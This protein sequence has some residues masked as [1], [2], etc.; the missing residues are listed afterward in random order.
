MR[1]TNDGM[2]GFQEQEKLCR[3]LVVLWIPDPLR[4]IGQVDVGP[5]FVSDP[6]NPFRL[7]ERE[8]KVWLQAHTMLLFNGS[9]SRAEMWITRRW[10][11]K[12]RLGPGGL[13]V[14]ERSY[15]YHRPPITCIFPF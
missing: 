3:R 7:N 11:A 10:L 5:A 12:I 13:Y 2:V 4:D 6:R 8:H 14:D 15:K 1:Y 9:A